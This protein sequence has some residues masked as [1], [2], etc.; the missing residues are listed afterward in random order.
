MGRQY[1]PRK[2]S[3]TTAAIKAAAK[4]PI[5]SDFPKYPLESLVTIPPVVLIGYVPETP[6]SINKTGGRHYGTYQNNKKAYQALGHRLAVEYKNELAP[7]RGYRVK[8]TFAVP[9]TK[10][11]SADPQNYLSGPSVK[12]ILDGITRSGY[13]IPD[14]NQTWCEASCVL[15][16]HPDEI[17]VKVELASPVDNPITWTEN[18]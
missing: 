2:V 3:H 11:G 16:K 1:A 9:L 15:W 4:T 17:R 12:G 14:D 10:P 18:S 13:L 7:F 5:V 6:R 8:I